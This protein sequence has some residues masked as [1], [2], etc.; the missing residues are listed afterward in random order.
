MIRQAP[1]RGR[2]RRC[3]GFE[4][5]HVT[6]MMI[7]KAQLHRQ[8]L[9]VRA[10]EGCNQEGAAKQGLLP[11]HQARCS[12]NHGRGHSKSDSQDR[13]CWRGRARAGTQAPATA[14]AQ[15]PAAA[16]EPHQQQVPPESALLAVTEF[17]YC[18]NSEQLQL[19]HAILQA[20]LQTLRL[21]Q[22][23]TLGQL[24]GA[25][26]QWQALG[27]QVQSPL[28]CLQRRQHMLC[29]SY[30]HCRPLDRHTCPAAVLQAVDLVPMVKQRRRLSSS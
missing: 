5:F 23:P 12:Q 17:L 2:A 20:Q 16:Q 13:S 7:I 29:S 30:R 9:A 19:Q 14:V 6:V 22:V 3:D 11:Q 24:Q 8:A 26:L 4:M 10:A 18:N 21:P 15:E 25:Q 27:L 28:Q 1:A